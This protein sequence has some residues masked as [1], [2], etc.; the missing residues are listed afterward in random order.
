MEFPQPG[1]ILGDLKDRFNIGQNRG[2]YQD[3]PYDD[4]CDDAYSDDYG[5]NGYDESRY[6][7]SYSSDINSGRT[8][9]IRYPKLV[10][11]E[12]ASASASSLGVAA[13]DRA[14]E[15]KAHERSFAG[16]SNPAYSAPAAEPAAA[17]ASTTYRQPHIYGGSTPDWAPKRESKDAAVTQDASSATNGVTEALSA[18]DAREPLG[19]EGLN[20]LFKPTTQAS[21][22]DSARREL[23]VV[24]PHAYK[25][26]SDVA[27]FLRQGNVVVLDLRATDESLAKRLLDFSFGVAAALEAQVEC[28]YE[29]VYALCKGQA[30]SAI[31][32]R[33]L[34]QQGIR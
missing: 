24:R 11:M 7:D 32:K 34:Y 12:E 29:K 21:A 10:T 14:R 31:E 18:S 13:A 19:S 15:A 16:S 2:G 5:P 23:K 22:S 25:D 20:G 9:V 4:Y 6:G 28:P 26:V 17:N 30:L 27:A 3:Q 8:E 1:N 33:S